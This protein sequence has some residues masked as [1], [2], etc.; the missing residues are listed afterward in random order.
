MRGWIVSLL[1][2]L[3]D[4]GQRPFSHVL[5]TALV[6]IGL[7]TFSTGC[8]GQDDAWARVR[9][10]GVIRVG[11]DASF[12]P[13]EWIA[14]DG[15]LVGFDVDLAREIGRRLGLEIQFVANLP[16][17]GLYDALSVGR[18]DAVISALVVDPSRMA[19]FAYS[20][21]YFDAGQVLVARRGSDLQGIDDLAGR[22]LAV[23]FGS[24]GDQQAR[25][26][27]RRMPDLTLFHFETAAEAV[28]VVAAAE[29]DVALVD[30]VSALKACAANDRLV[31]LGAPVLSEPYAI[32]VRDDSA[33]LLRAVDRALS[34]MRADGT[35]DRLI[36]EWVSVP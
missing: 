29:V 19:D 13:F 22:T 33:A 31:I 15:S 27:A 32:A 34:D 21:S 20:A 14:S 18:V 35:L 17:D 5:L 9:A 8:S 7:L 24:Q 10:Q 4:E 28:D 30:H 12:P 11:M 1:P 16:Y 2:V 6:V 25:R 36:A 23:G 3:R 26:W